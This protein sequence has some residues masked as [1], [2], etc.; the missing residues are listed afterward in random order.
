MTTTLQDFEIAYKEWT[1]AT[2]NLHSLLLKIP[3]GCEAVPKE[4]RI[5]VVEVAAKHA[6]FMSSAQPI[7]FR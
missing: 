1:H 3:G 2:K 4:V 6:A 5:A 7:I